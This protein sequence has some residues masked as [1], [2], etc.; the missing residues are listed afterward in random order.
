[1]F[2]PC[3]LKDLEEEDYHVLHVTENL[4]QA[5]RQIKPLQSV[6][7]IWADAI[8][9][10]Q[11][12]ETDKSW[13]VAQM[14]PIYQNARV[15]M[16]WLGSGGVHTNQMMDTIKTTMA[17]EVERLL[18][19]GGEAGLDALHLPSTFDV[20]SEFQALTEMPYWKRAWVR[21]EISSQEPDGIM[22]SYGR[23]IIQFN[24]LLYLVKAMQNLAKRFHQTSET[25]YDSFQDS[26]LSVVSS[27]EFKAVSDTLDASHA[28]LGRA[29]LIHILF[30]WLRRIYLWG[31]GPLSKRILS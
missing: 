4:F 27:H 13:Q 31:D 20:L 7:Y 8:C 16:V 25:R 19:Q 23:R 9:I 26:V 14:W 29:R 1:M 30:T 6:E 11:A 15:V 3:N 21:Q 17:Q 28:V 18:G 24:H 5:L 10:N 22:I 2:F 12:D